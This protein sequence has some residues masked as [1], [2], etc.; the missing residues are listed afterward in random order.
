M[1]ILREKSVAAM[2]TWEE[3]FFQSEF[4]HGAGVRN[5]VRYPGGFLAMWK[6][7]EAKRKFPTRYLVSAKQTLAEFVKC[8]DH[9]YRNQNQ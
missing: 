5:H 1:K 2:Q 9:S 4:T 7:L 8:D 6:A 3:S